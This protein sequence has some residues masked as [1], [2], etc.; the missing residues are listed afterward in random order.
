VTES[1]LAASPEE[2]QERE[3]RWRG[4]ARGEDL[5]DEGWRDA[6]ELG[7]IG[8]ESQAARCATRE[9][10]HLEGTNERARCA[11]WCK[12]ARVRGPDTRQMR[13]G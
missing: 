10:W 12:K 11:V 6:T 3:R 8:W 4:R 7:E 1:I 2:E 13:D 9:R 5:S